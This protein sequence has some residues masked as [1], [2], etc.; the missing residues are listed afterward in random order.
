MKRHN[1]FD[2]AGLHRPPL[3]FALSFLVFLLAAGCQA[4]GGSGDQDPL[5]TR[6]QVDVL[7]AKV[8]TYN[9]KSFLLHRDLSKTVMELRE[10]VVALENLVK[11][12][13]IEIK[14]LNEKV[15]APPAKVVEVP[16]AVTTPPPPSISS[17]EALKQIEVQLLKLR[18]KGDVDEIAKALLPIAPQAA[19]RV[20]EVMKEA[21]RDVDLLR[22]LEQ[23]LARMP[24][25]DLK[26][27]LAEALKDPRRRNTAARVVGHAGNLELSR[28]L[29]PFTSAAEDDFCLEVGAALVRCRNVV[30][31]PA[32]IR[33][34]RSG[35]RSTRFLA[36]AELRPL[37][38]NNAHGYDST[39]D[40]EANADAIRAWEEWFE[41]NRTKLFQ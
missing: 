10:R 23:L 4:P 41:K 1:G 19:A 25:G 7:A 3:L 17:E 31:V 34:L 2:P 35:D 36:L 12:Y 5:A 18:Q 6:S 37:S 9:E 33:A 30:G 15:A 39:K 27:P 38:G 11:A 28:L 40:R 26:I 22:R 32:L 13:D 20:C 8:E 29:E 21:I 14:R 24:A 16:P